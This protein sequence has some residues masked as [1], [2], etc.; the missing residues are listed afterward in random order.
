MVQGL[1][2]QRLPSSLPFHLTP[3]LLAHLLLQAHHL[4]THLCT[5]AG[6]VLCFVHLFTEYL[7]GIYCVPST[8]QGIDDRINK[9]LSLEPLRSSHSGEGD[10]Y[11]IP[12]NATHLLP[13][14]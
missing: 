14:V 7:L 6:A 9:R 2:W 4:L 1:E 12:P 3:G 10:Y 13:P 8:M 11:E 5:F